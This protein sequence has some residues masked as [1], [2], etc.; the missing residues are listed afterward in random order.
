M[1]IRLGEL[2]TENGHLKGT[3]ADLEKEIEN[4][5]EAISGAR[6]DSE[7]WQRECE[8]AK[9]RLHMFYHFKRISRNLTKVPSSRSIRGFAYCAFLWEKSILW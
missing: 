7:T 1:T 8:N 9:V 3:I 2:E 4:L 6:G 5:R